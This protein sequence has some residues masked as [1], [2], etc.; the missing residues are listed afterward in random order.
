[1]CSCFDVVPFPSLPIIQV[2]ISGMSMQLSSHPTINSYIQDSDYKFSAMQS[3][4]TLT[5]HELPEQISPKNGL[6]LLRFS[7][8]ALL[9]SQAVPV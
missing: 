6:S 3:M 5:M 1:M 8:Q 2:L 7:G 9:H 4:H